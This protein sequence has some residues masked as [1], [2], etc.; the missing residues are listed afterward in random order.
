MLTRAAVVI[1]VVYFQVFPVQGLIDRTIGS[2]SALSAYHDPH[3]GQLI[4]SPRAPQVHGGSLSLAMM[5]SISGW[6]IVIFPGLL[7]LRLG[8]ST[9]GGH[10]SPNPV[11]VPGF[12]LGSTRAP[13]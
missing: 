12:R 6:L 1:A 13:A 11:R 9:L 5:A 4:V 8:L 2:I 3:L 7:V 10:K